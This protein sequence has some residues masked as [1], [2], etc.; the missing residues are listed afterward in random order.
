MNNL[1]KYLVWFLVALL[2]VW[3]ITY[4]ADNWTIG[5]LF[6]QV[7]TE[8]KLLW[9]NIANNTVTTDKLAN[10]TVTKPS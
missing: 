2:W 1:K 5:D 9:S 4:A 3:T 7:W 8:W 6:V 10:N